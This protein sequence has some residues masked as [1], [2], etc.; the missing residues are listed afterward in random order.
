MIPVTV[1][2][3]KTIALFGLG[4]SG[5][6][7]AKALKEGGAHP[8]LFDESAERCD[9]ARG[10]GYEVQNLRELD[11][12]QV[13]ALVLSPGVPLTHPEPHWSVE[14][15]RRYEVPV[16]G[17][18]ELFFSEFLARG[19]CDKVIAI[20]GTNGKSTTT[21]LATHLLKAAG[22]RVEMGGNIGVGVLDLTDFGS[23]TV[24][25]IELSSYQIDLTP[26]MVP[27]AA[28]LLNITPDHIDRHGTVENYAEVKGQIFSQLAFDQLAV[29]SLDDEYCEKISK[30]IPAGVPT[31]FV[32]HSQNVKD[33][34][35]IDGTSLTMRAEGRTVNRLDLDGIASLRGLHNM[36]N[37]AFAYLLCNHVCSLDEA[38]IAGLRTFP[39]LAHRM[40]QI[41]QYA[42]DG[43][44]ILFINDSKA[45]N[46]DASE[47]ALMSFEKIYWIVGGVAK[48][49][50]IEGLSDHF[51][52]VQKAYLIGEETG[53]FAACLDAHSV[54]YAECRTLEVAVDLAF[55]DALKEEQLKG[56]QSPAIL[57][58][59]AAASFDQYAN[60]EIRGAAFEKI[61]SR[62]DGVLTL[63]GIDQK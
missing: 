24:Y 10:A 25:V 49:G 33:G 28:G 9:A 56:S 61:V 60:F 6:S 35:E 54:K 20:T 30:S 23:K 39:G 13:Q 42:E 4:L 19:H 12:R 5:I 45:T 59:P 18:T 44:E 37:A 17:D 14:L 8:I 22:V 15:A 27:S 7:A 48:E 36:Q 52:Q 41:G 11:W 58:S 26:T 38:M 50:G 63:P 2:R 43:R 51:S 16:I 31:K 62:I 46:A 29:V 55:A 40:Q 1:Y 21:A 3:D 47:Q 34:I 32:S 53:E 57:L